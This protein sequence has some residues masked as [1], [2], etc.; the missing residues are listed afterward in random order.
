VV[1]PEIEKMVICELEPLAPR[2]STTYFG[3]QN[4]N[5]MNDPRTHIVYDDA[6]HFLITSKDRYDI[7]TSDPLDP[8]AKG[9]ATLYTREFF[10]AVKEHLNPGGIFG[11]FVQLYESN[12]AAVMSELATFFENIYLTLLKHRRFPEGVFAGNSPRMKALRTIL[13]ARK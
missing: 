10:K 12:E 2:A 9:T 1:H 4:Y 6:R 3:K 7:I 11:Q 5:V 8:W 13:M